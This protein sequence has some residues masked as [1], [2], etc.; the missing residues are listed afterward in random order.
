[1]H[2][3]RANVRGSTRLIAVYL[4][5]TIVGCYATLRC[6]DTTQLVML[7][8][9]A[10]AVKG[11]MKFTKL[12]TAAQYIVVHNT[13][14]GREKEMKRESHLNEEINNSNA[15]AACVCGGAD[16]FLSYNNPS[17]F[18]FPQK[19]LLPCSSFNNQNK[20]KPFC[21]SAVATYT[22]CYPV[23]KSHQVRQRIGERSM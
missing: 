4:V 8:I 14:T 22:A 13:K 5:G 10:E 21:E 12:L 6:S 9:L 7:Y 19:R 17:H 16:V 1:M 20:P 3:Q 2:G 23:G 15:P 18:F 11:R